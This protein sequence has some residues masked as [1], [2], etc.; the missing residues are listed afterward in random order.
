MKNLILTLII[1]LPLTLWGQGW[2][3]TFGG[4]S[5]DWGISVQ[6]TN[7]GGFIIT[8]L[9]R[10]FGNGEDDV[11][12]IKTDENGNEQ[13]T[14]TFGGIDD[15]SGYSIQITNDGGYIICGGTKSFGNGGSDVYLI[16]TDEN[17]N[18]QWSKTFGGEGYEIGSCVQQTND[19]G[20]IISGSTGSFGNGGSDVYLIKTDG[21]GDSLWTRTFGGTSSEEGNSIQQTTDE[22]Y[23]IVG[24][25]DSYGNGDMDIYLIKTDD[26]GNEEWSKTFGGIDKDRGYSV[27][28]TQDGGY[29][30]TGWKQSLENEGFEE[31]YD[32]YLIKTDGNGNELWTNLFGEESINERGISVKQTNDNGFVIVGYNDFD[33]VEEDIYF[34]KTDE[35]GNEQWTQTF[36]GEGY[37]IGNSV[38]QTTDGGYII[39]GLTDSYGN[40]DEDVYLI[41]TNQFGNITSTFEIPLPKPDRKLEKTVNL[42]G[43]EI[44][45]QTN[46]PIIEIFND[47]SVKKKIIME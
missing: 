25:T 23:I 43:Q 8:G 34:L 24:H 38:Q 13:W 19:G 22:G 37:E 45:S 40:G 33:E 2:E 9:T 42:I 10:S 4:S 17:G 16:K 30:I 12:L 15:E 47:G 14:K 27:Q 5:S 46:T 31:D 44:K 7:D 28:Q 20:Y 32:I 11:Y 29:I 6:Q 21:N 3:Q 39:V 18:E 41:K 26:N 1:T 35:N 36:G